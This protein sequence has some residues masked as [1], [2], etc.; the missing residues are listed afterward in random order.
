MRQRTKLLVLLA[1]L[2]LAPLTARELAQSPQLTVE[3][4]LVDARVGAPARYR[5]LVLYPIAL[6]ARK[7]PDYHTLDQ[8]LALGSLVIRETSQQGNVNQLSINNQG[9]QPVYIMAG[10]ILQGA[11]QDRV[12]QD[13]LWLPAR[14]GETTVAAFCIE[15]GRWEYETPTFDKSRPVAANP[16]V[17]AA[18]RESAD[19]ST[20]WSSV[21]RSQ[22]GA[23]YHASTNL[24]KT[25]E[26][27][28]V[29]ARLDG[30]LDALDAFARDNPEARGVVVQVGDRILVTDL[31]A[32][33]AG[34]V[35]KFPKLLPSYALEAANEGGESASANP[36]RT[37]SFL[38]RIA[39]ARFTSKGTPGDGK[40]LELNS[41]EGSGSALVLEQVVVHLEAFPR[42][43]SSNDRH[44]I[45]IQRVYPR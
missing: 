18:A 40:L 43:R 7:L 22:A 14:S 3:N 8:A 31:F 12:L 13:D 17:R 23:G 15:R 19:Q 24:G 44:P 39:G 28:R 29:K 2:V 30:Y 6:P 33:R 36:D 1:L 20:V 5:N 26:D 42:G 34:F 16:T 9:H 25:F 41:P 11:K 10:E 27:P 37:L 32:D 4:W 35:L 45:P 21:E 38:R